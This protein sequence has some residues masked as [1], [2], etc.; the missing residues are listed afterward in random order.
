MD[1]FDV[2][3]SKEIKGKR[4]KRTMPF[5]IKHTLLCKAI[6]NQRFTYYIHAY[7][8]DSKTNLIL[9]TAIR[10]NDILYYKFKQTYQLLLGSSFQTKHSCIFRYLIISDIF[11]LYILLKMLVLYNCIIVQF[12]LRIVSKYYL[13]NVFISNNKESKPRA[14]IAYAYTCHSMHCSWIKDP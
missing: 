6:H 7:C 4:R 13:F 8:V 10:N 11:W 9:E 14:V 12:L 3:L 5:P 1:C 2:E